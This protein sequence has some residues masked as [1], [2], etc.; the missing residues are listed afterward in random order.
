MVLENGK[1]M[2]ADKREVTKHEGVNAC[3]PK[4]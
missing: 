3:Q 4:G 2:M 1:W